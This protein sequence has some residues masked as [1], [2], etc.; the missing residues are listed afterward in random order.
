MGQY[1]SLLTITSFFSIM[2]LMIIRPREGVVLVKLAASN[3]GDIPMPEKSYDSITNGVI[4][5][6]NPK[7]TE[8]DFQVGDSGF[9]RLYK[10]DCRVT[11][12]NDE[13]LAL[14][15]ITDILGT[16]D[17]TTNTKD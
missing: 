10:D 12:D 9:W 11:G 2:L 16:A 13:K 1:P 3:Y 15:N 14:I 7:D 4:V 6:T 5:A 17:G 8:S